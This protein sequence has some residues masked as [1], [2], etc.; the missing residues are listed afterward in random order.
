MRELLEQI[1]WEGILC[2]LDIHGA[3]Q[4]FSIRYCQARNELQNLTRSLCK[5][6]ECSLA[7]NRKVDI[8]YFWKYV[9]SHLKV[10]L[11]ISSLCCDNISV[12]YSDLEKC[13]LF[14]NFFLVYSQVKIVHLFLTSNSI[15]IIFITSLAITPAIVFDKLIHLDP[16]NPEGW[17]TLSL[18]ETIQQ[19]CTPLCI[20]FRNL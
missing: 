18:K 1:D 17:P 20:L 15:V 8:K 4:L 16:S 19:L 12:T 3:W 13:E 11:S 14:N 6:Y 7:S 10:C 2:P 9:N 5:T